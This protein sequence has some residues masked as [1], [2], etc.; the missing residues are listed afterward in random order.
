MGYLN[1]VPGST[2][3]KLGTILA[4][5]VTDAGNFPQQVLSSYPGIPT[6]ASL[7]APLFDPVINNM[8]P[9]ISV[10]PP[11]DSV[12]LLPVSLALSPPV[13]VELTPQYS[14]LLGIWMNPSLYGASVS[15]GFQ[16]L[17]I[18]SPKWSILYED[19]Q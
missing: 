12:Q 15:T 1:T 18:G 5:L 13:P 3:G 4:G 19:G 17:Y 2:Y 16:G 6:D 10:A 14:P 7:V 11:P 8:P 9:S